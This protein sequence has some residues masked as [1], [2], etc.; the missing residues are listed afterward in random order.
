MTREFRTELLSESSFRDFIFI[1]RY[2]EKS[3]SSKKDSGW[4]VHY[5]C[6]WHNVGTWFM[7]RLFPMILSRVWYDFPNRRFQTT[8]CNMIH[9][10]SILYFEWYKSF[11]QMHALHITH[12]WMWTY[13]II[14][15]VWMGMYFYVFSWNLTHKNI[16]CRSKSLLNLIKWSLCFG[17]QVLAYWDVNSLTKTIKEWFVCINVIP[18]FLT[19]LTDHPQI[20][21]RDKKWFERNFGVV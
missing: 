12:V 2:F 15:T 9:V 21:S 17:L 6:V 4:Q 3:G 14:T 13:R 5:V 11:I 7:I 10:K 1:T 8:S 20:E 16:Y 19:V 18:P